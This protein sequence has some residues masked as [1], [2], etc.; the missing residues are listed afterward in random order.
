[1]H[2]GESTN[3][4]VGVVVDGAGGKFASVDDHIEGRS[5]TYVEVEYGLVRIPAGLLVT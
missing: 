5:A 3:A 4:S 2:G 1:V